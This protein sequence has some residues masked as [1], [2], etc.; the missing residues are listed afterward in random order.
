MAIAGVDQYFASVGKLTI[1]GTDY[2][3]ASLKAVL[4]AE[5]DAEKA[6][7]RS[8]A[9]VSQEVATIRPVRATARSMRSGL[10][11]Y[12]LGTYGA[13][14]VQMLKDFGMKVPA[15]PGQTSA[16]TKAEAV[17]KGRATR[18][19]REEALQ[20]AVPSLP[21]KGQTAASNTPVKA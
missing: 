7:D 17:V 10:R 15:V 9:A 1:A 4:Q 12:I 14:A 16:E 13:T 6:L 2:T 3:P 19:A 20:N 21:A 11:K 5:I 18:K 8:R